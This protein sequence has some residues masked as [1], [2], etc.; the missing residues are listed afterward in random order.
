LSKDS[1]GKYPLLL[2]PDNFTPLSRT[3]WA[4][5]LITQRFKSVVCPEAKG[6]KVGE[7]W[8]FS[9]DP[10]FPSRLPD[11]TSLIDLIRAHPVDILGKELASKSSHPTC[12][13]LIKLLNADEP[14]S[15]QIHPADD[16]PF[17]KPNECGKPESWLILSA[18][19]GA[20]LYLGFNRSMQRDE[21]RSIMLSGDSAR[22]V[23]NFVPVQSGDY[24]EIEPGVPHAIGPGLCLLEPQRIVFGKSGKTFRFWDWG[25]KYNKQGQSDINGEPRELHLDAALRL[26]DPMTQVGDRFVSS[27]RRKASKA[28]VGRHSQWLRFPPNPYYQVNLLK[29][30]KGDHLHLQLQDGY[31]VAS[32]LSGSMLIE[33][34]RRLLSVCT[35][36]TMLIPAHCHTSKLSPADDEV[37]IAIVVPTGVRISMQS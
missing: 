6:A 29:I 5:S 4:G 35:G 16:D 1:I 32:V 22:D 12:E 21:L 7:S 13:L 33:N 30:A 27:L 18:E 17:L 11:G 10:D 28:A 26:A 34:Q 20:G 19:P 23:L 24:F 14:L 9:C 15:L 37:E 36:H 31:A 3:P 8:E 25:R 2:R